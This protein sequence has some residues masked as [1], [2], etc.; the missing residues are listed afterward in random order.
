MEECNV[1][2]EQSFVVPCFHGCSFKTCNKCISNILI[3]NYEAKICYQCP[4]CRKKVITNRSKNCNCYGDH[5]IKID[6]KFTK[7]CYKNI[8]I[9]KKI[10]KMY[11]EE[12][13]LEYNREFIDQEIEEVNDNQEYVVPIHT[14]TL[15][16]ALNPNAT[17][18]YP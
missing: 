15:V 3:I 17:P 11:Q 8:D 12:L 13:F 1:C 10:F 14:P 6:K 7:F 5:P 18:W 4:A 16:R 9:M 2:F